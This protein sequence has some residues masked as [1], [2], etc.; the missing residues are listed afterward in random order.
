MY[1]QQEFVADGV[2]LA[3]TQGLDALGE[4]ATQGLNALGG[5][6]APGQAAN[7]APAPVPAAADETGAGADRVPTPT[8]QAVAE[9]EL[10]SKSLAMRASEVQ[11]VP[12]L[13]LS[14]G[15]ALHVVAPAEED[16]LTPLLPFWALPV[17]RRQHCHD[18]ASPR[19]RCRMHAAHP[20][21]A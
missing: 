18:L 16:L 7:A 15:H 13:E 6:A 12:Q 1:G 8:V 10:A 19:S 4:A 2:V 5:A 14:C 9:A 3:A 11:P 21:V 17:C 20:P